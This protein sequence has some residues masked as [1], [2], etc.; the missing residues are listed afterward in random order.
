MY[1]LRFLGRKREGILNFGFQLGPAT[2]K[3]TLEGKDG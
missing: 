1:W 2:L 3:F